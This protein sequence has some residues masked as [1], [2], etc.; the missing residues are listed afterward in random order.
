MV[1]ILKFEL[2]AASAPSVIAP[3]ADGMESPNPFVDAP[4]ATLKAMLLPSGTRVPL[5]SRMLPTVIVL[6]LAAPA[7]EVTIAG[8]AVMVAECATS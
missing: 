3:P 5:I 4:L 6:V 2:L 1:N 7:D 8:L